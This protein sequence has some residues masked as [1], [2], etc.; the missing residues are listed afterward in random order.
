[1]SQNLPRNFWMDPLSIAVYTSKFS[2]RQF[3]TERGGECFRLWWGRGGSCNQVVWITGSRLICSAIGAQSAH[4]VQSWYKCAPQ[5]FQVQLY[6]ASTHQSPGGKN[7]PE[8]LKFQDG[9]DEIRLKKSFKLRRWTEVRLTQLCCPAL[10]PRPHRSLHRSPPP[11]SP[12]GE[13]WANHQQ[14]TAV[15]PLRTAEEGVTHEWVGQGA[16]TCRPRIPGWG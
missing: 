8:I 6:C 9:E 1:M 3:A 14:R 16:I 10:P 2:T 15:R 5:I 13:G 7:R 4:E 11:R 12:T